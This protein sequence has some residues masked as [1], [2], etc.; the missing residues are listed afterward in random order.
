MKK[1]LLACD[2]AKIDGRLR[3]S[4]A[5]LA[6]SCEVVVV[7][8]GYS[9]FDEIGEQAFD[10]IIIDSLLPEIDSLEVIESIQYVD[11]GVPIIL[12]FNHT[13]RGVWDSVRQLKAYPII[14]PFKPL[15]FLRLVDKLL[16][17]HLT[18]YRQ[19]AERLKNILE[20]LCSQTGASYAFLVEESGQVLLSSGELEDVPPELFTHFNNNE[21]VPGTG[22]QALLAPDKDRFTHYPLEQEHGL[23]LTLVT[24][25]LH[26]ALISP[27]PASH[28]ASPETWHVVHEAANQIK[29]ALDEQVKTAS[30]INK[31]HKV[32]PHVFIPLKSN[33]GNEPESEGHEDEDEKVGVNW[34]L[35]SNSSTVLNRLDEFC[36]LT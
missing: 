34:N 13:Y 25:N 3:R 14:R 27:I 17:Q 1:I 6:G 20:T 8:D 18:H 2:H 9:T 7:N 15:R 31:G 4:L 33:F 22:L 30:L 29:I 23:Y 5:H 19:L 28:E 24:H 11:P 16:H 21:V 26:L 10:L 36:R 35:L 32:P 12:M